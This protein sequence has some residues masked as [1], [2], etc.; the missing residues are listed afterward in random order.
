MRIQQQLT[1]LEDSGL[2]R[3]VINAAEL[4]YLF[5]HVLV[6]D[7]A[8]ASL[9]RADRKSLHH[10]VGETLE[11]LYPD[12]QGSLILLP[13]LG[14]HYLLA[15][16]YARAFDYFM[17]SGEAAAHVYANL[18]ALTHLDQ[19]RAILAHHR[20]PLDQFE[21]LYLQR[22]RVLELM[23]DYD[24]AL[25]NYEELEEIAR[26]RHA[27][28]LEL[29]A[30]IARLPI[31]V[32]P[33][34]HFDVSHGEA[35]ALTALDLARVTQN[36]AA[37]SKIY[38]SLMRLRIA[39]LQPE[40]ALE[41]GERSLALAREL[42]LREQ[43]AFTLNDIYEV[44]LSNGQAERAW[45]ALNE[46]RSLW[47]DLDNL[48]MLADNFSA[49]AMFM[50]FAGRYQQALMF[51][52]ESQ[53]IS[54][55]IGNLW[56]QSYSRLMLW[57][58]YF[59]W[60]DCAEAIRSCELCQDYGS[61]AGF[62]VGETQAMANLGLIYAWLGDDERG[63]ELVQASLKRAHALAP[64]LLLDYPLALLAYLEIGRGQYEPAREI[65]QRLEQTQSPH[66]LTL[67]NPYFLLLKV[68]LAWFDQ[69]L[70]L[71]AQLLESGLNLVQTMG[72][73][74][75]VPMVLFYLGRLHHKQG[76]IEM[77]RTALQQARAEAEALEQR[78]VLWEILALQGQIAAEQGQPAEAEQ[79]RQQARAILQFI[80]DHC[81]TDLRPRLLN[82]PNV[83]SVLN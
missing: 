55:R 2:V 26:Q 70:E 5:R 51:S 78:R 33:T 67:L 8:Y 73:R 50:V 32:V 63:L 64:D 39:Q 68:Q 31:Y 82:L 9:L 61:A 41:A 16:D 36:G 4:E 47:R 23:S 19:A 6:Q 17:Q 30:L 29:A 48:P 56:N 76:Q 7:A 71:V 46:A 18:E 12:L 80:I 11:T 27:P 22:G 1:V 15:E 69:N 42:N 62:M 58:I 35:L 77:A 20:P 53:K 59:D 72:V 75:L 40:D 38:W 66:Q 10:I 45:G 34:A 79:L 24:A 37:E 28:T 25:R 54:E 74:P 65:V 57:M 49:S 3:P 83:R 60:G 44:Y 81:P 21:H 43:L 13:I 52:R 14:H